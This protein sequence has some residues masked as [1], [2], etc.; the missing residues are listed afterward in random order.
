MKNNLFKKSLNVFLL[1]FV[2]SIASSSSVYAGEKNLVPLGCTVGIILDMEGV[3]IIDTADV[4]DET[5]AIKTPAKDAGMQA[6]DRIRCINGTA[7]NSVD[8]LEKIVQKNES[9]PLSVQF[10]RGTEQKE[11]TISP[12][13]SDE[14]E[15]VRLGIWIKDAASGIGTMT[16]YDPENEFFGALGHGILQE[17]GDQL[18]PIKSGFIVKSTVVSIQKGTK[19]TPGELISV[20]AEDQERIGEIKNNSQVGLSGSLAIHE[21]NQKDL[22]P[23][24]VADRNEV[25]TGKAEIRANI[26]ENYIETFSVEIQKINKDVTNTK[27]MIIKVTDPKLLEKTGGIVQGMSGSPIIQ[28]GKLVGAITHVFV[29]D[30]TRG[31]GIFIENMLSEV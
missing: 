6:G 20:F 8:D 3:T 12:V 29:N 4:K 7:V 21:L 14:D 31:Y 26:N 5:G 15:K 1:F 16:Y 13:R 2:V 10:T 11:C 30:P 23:I 9:K 22:Q 24:P 17:T 28:D 25:T 19:G 18:L 27:G